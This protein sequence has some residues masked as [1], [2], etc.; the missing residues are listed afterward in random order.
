MNRYGK[1]GLIIFA[2]I[3]MSSVSMAQKSTL[4]N[5]VKMDKLNTITT[6]VPLLMIAPDARAGAMGDAGV[7]ST[8]DAN[9]MHWNP[10]KYA[11][12]EKSM[13]ISASYTP[14]L[15]ALISDINLAYLSYYR[16]MN[17]QQ[18]FG[19]SMLYFSLGQIAFTDNN[20]ESLGSF[21]PNEFSLDATYARKLSDNFSGGVA[22]R[23]IYSNLTG[24]IYVGGA[25][26][27]PGHSV[28]TDVSGY[29]RKEVVV[30]KKD[31]ILGLGF[32]FSNIGSKISYTETL[33]RDFIPMNLRVGG[34]LKMELDQYNTIEFLADFNK[35]L[36]PTQPVYYSVGDVN[37]NGDTV[38]NGNEEIQFGRD[39][40]RSVPN[41]I[42][43]SFYDAPGGFSEE[44]HEFT[45]S[46]GMEYW[47]DKQFALRGG[48]FHEN[49]F[50]GNR[51]YFTLG[52]G[53]K[54]NVFSLDFSFLI[55]TGQRHPLENTLRFTLLF[56]FDAFKEQ[57]KAEAPN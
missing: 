50:K 35:L 23:Y 33:E 10:A 52:A 5:S 48:F 13:G 19:L 3:A 28:A 36:V 47:Y 57:N 11:F 25:E 21:T 56:D 6:A 30:G 8:P 29:Y 24:G 46:V 42:F 2:S 9:S 15:K 20:G 22:F 34:S 51:E 31:A 49:P 45:Y 1:K 40:F 55:P 27:H 12:I 7:A 16:K 18:A 38:K 53:L 44:L 43:T 32:N 37:A 41:A 17:D 14:W 54:Y 4:T 26:T 39:P